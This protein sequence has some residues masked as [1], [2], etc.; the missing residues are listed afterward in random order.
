MNRREFLV[1]PLLLVGLVEPVVTT[2][3]PAWSRDKSD[4][5]WVQGSVVVPALAEQ[6]WKRLERADQWA[7][8]FTDIK[9]L[10][11]AFRDADEWKLK[12]ETHTF[13][14]GAHDYHV[15][16]SGPYSSTIF[17]E[18]PGISGIAYL[19]ARE[20]KR[21]RPSDPVETRVHYSLFVEMK[22]PMPWFGNEAELRKKQEAMV[23][24]NLVDLERA[25][26][27]PRA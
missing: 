10:R 23:E 5:R 11:V 15:H 8:V 25:F 17:I 24:K 2:R 19:K 20:V 27:P 14:C 3:A 9:A 13:P 21:A 12:V 22:K 7:A 26:A 1:A 16:L 18:A 6:V 4:P